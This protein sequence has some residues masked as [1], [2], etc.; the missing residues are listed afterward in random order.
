M[1]FVGEEVCW[2]GQHGPTQGIAQ[3]IIDGTLAAT[4][5]QYAATPAFLMTS[6]VTSGLSYG[7][8]SIAVEVS[9]K[10]NRQA[11]GSDII[12]NAFD[13]I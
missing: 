10:R 11:S 5:D 9:T 7:P 13:V 8:H 6:F 2:I 3:V 1:E 12:I 4:V